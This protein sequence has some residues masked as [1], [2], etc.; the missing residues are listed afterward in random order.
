MIPK[1][2]ASAAFLLLLISCATVAQLAPASPENETAFAESQMLV[3][4]VILDPTPEDTTPANLAGIWRVMMD[5]NEITMA[6]IQSGSALRGECKSEA[7]DPWNGILAGQIAANA[8]N[9]AIAANRGDVLVSTI[10]SGT[11]DG[12]FMEGR[13]ATADQDGNFSQGDFSAERINIDVDLYVPTKVQEPSLPTS[14]TV[15]RFQ[16][17]DQSAKQ[18]VEQSPVEPAV[19]SQGRTFTDV[20]D[21]AKGIDPNIMPPSAPL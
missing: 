1:L 13:F 7:E 19:Q 10:L 6:V 3:E 11:V 21:L 4:N 5:E 18:S 14:V 9:I 20:R 15:D 16:I 2:T 17:M 12:D 8:A